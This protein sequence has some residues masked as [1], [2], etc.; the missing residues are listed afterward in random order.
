MS[1][2]A[3]ARDSLAQAVDFEPAFLLPLEQSNRVQD[4]EVMRDGDDLQLQRLGEFAHTARRGTQ[5]ID[6]PQP[7]GIGQGPQ[8]LGAVIRLQR[9]F[10]HV[11]SA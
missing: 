8:H 9:I 4:A 11:F 10:R 1:P 7:H 5:R 2:F 3:E 6:N